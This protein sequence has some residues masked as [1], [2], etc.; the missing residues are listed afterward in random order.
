[1]FLQNERTLML[2]MLS[3]MLA[4]QVFHNSFLFLVAQQLYVHVNI[5]FCPF[6]IMEIQDLLNLNKTNLQTTKPN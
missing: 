6:Q 2:G 3:A 1:M 5:F 4:S